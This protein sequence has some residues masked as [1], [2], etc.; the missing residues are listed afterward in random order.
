MIFTGLYQSQRNSHCIYFAK[1]LVFF[2]CISQLIEYLSSTAFSRDVWIS[3]TLA[4]VSPLDFISERHCYKS[5][6][7]L[8]LHLTPSSATPDLYLRKV[9]VF[10][11]RHQVWVYIWGKRVIRTLGEE[12]NS[13]PNAP[14]P[15]CFIVGLLSSWLGMTLPH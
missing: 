4:K 2:A 11:L 13:S 5:F 1:L 8:Y 14:A 9:G 10:A 12:L 15:L 6:S 3:L 7:F